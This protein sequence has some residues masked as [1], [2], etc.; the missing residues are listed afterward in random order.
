M[1]AFKFFVKDPAD[2]VTY[3]VD[4]NEDSFLGSDTIT[5]TPEWTVPAGITKA[6]QSNT[7]TT[8][9]ARLSGGTAGVDYEVACKITTVAG[10]TFERTIR[11]QV[12]ER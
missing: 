12:R 2:V 10:E 8:A 1:S 6:S 3:V 11:V 5:G 9:S 4:W 7:A